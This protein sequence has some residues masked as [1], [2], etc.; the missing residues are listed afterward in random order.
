M[1]SNIPEI[2]VCVLDP[3]YTRL[4][5][6][7]PVEVTVEVGGKPGLHVSARSQLLNIGI[8]LIKNTNNQ[9]LQS[10][11]CELPKIYLIFDIF[12]LIERGHIAQNDLLWYKVK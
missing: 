9:L 6:F 2:T 4:K 8:G 11:Y 1:T 5:A 10:L 7:R 3:Q 12:V